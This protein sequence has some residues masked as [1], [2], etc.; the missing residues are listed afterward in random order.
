[1]LMPAPKAKPEVEVFWAFSV[2]Q[3]TTAPSQVWMVTVLAV[4]PRI[5][6]D[7]VKFI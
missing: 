1:M 2:R 7:T 5:V 3:V 4:V 6:P